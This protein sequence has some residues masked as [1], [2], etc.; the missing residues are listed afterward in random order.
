VAE[1]P[2]RGESTWQNKPGA[3]LIW[4][5]DGVAYSPTGLV[6]LAARES[7]GLHLSSVAGPRSW[8]DAS[9]RTLPEIAAAAE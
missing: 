3:P 9:G 6:L 1:D 5:K 7:A 8:Q 2:T 4:K